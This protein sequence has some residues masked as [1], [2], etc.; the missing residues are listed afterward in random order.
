MTEKNISSKVNSLEEKENDANLHL[1]K[2]DI[3]V[4]KRGAYNTNP[5]L[6]RHWWRHNDLLNTQWLTWFSTNRLYSLHTKTET[7]K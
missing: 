7:S 4:T 6:T 3:A 5:S 2:S 1:P